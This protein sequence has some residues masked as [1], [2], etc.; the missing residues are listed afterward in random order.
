MPPLQALA[1]SIALQNGQRLS[2]SSSLSSI[3]SISPQTVTEPV[4]YTIDNL[5]PYNVPVYVSRLACKRSTD[6]ILCH[7]AEAVTFVGLVYQVIITFFIVVRP[8][9]FNTWNTAN[10]RGRR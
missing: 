4:F 5:A 2:N 1:K 8:P 3:L 9:S 7:R 6:L 10:R